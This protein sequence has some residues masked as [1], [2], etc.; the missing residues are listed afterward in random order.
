M[1]WIFLIWFHLLN[2]FCNSFLIMK[3]QLFL[4]K[5]SC[6]SYVFVSSICSI[7]NESIWYIFF[8]LFHSCHQI[9]ISNIFFTEVAYLIFKVT[10]NFQ[11]QYF[12]M[13]TSSRSTITHLQRGRL[14]FVVSLL[15]TWSGLLLLKS[16][17]FCCWIFIKDLE[18]VYFLFI[19]YF[20]SL[21]WPLQHMK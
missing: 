4:S 16:F 7:K 10:F 2:M 6:N 9:Y 21:K 14:T 3:Q 5:H 11:K 1:Y 12:Q 20:V 13:S 19:L 8:I 15:L 17:Y 18:Q